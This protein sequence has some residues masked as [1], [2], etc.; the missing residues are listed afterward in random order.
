MSATQ[1]ITNVQVESDSTERIIAPGIEHAAE[2]WRIARDSVTLDLNPSYAY[3][4]YC[5][6]FSRT[7]RVAVVDGKVV[8][9][10]MG[11]VRPEKPHHLFVWQVAVDESYR[12]RGLAGRL[13]DELFSGVAASDDVHTVETTITDDN[14][15]S[16]NLFASFARRW[17]KAPMTVDPLFDGKHFPD[18]H[19]AEK[20]YEIGPI[21]FFDD[22][23][24]AEVEQARQRAESL[25]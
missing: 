9:Y 5:R 17:Q 21:F 3:L 22:E 23:L 11:H 13:L 20:L 19:D 2:M 8:G 6:D 1:A 16:Q 12:G 15:A 18:N 24:L 4:V 25:G 14:E 10:V 7:T